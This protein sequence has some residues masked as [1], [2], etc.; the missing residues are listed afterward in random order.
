MLVTVLSLTQHISQP[1]SQFP[2]AVYNSWTATDVNTIITNP[3][4]MSLSDTLNTCIL[5]HH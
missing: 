2:P 5:Q 1:A 3:V 4:P